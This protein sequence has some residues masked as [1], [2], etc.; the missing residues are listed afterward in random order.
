M[1][2]DENPERTPRYRG[3]SYTRPINSAKAAVPVIELT[4]R[5]D[6]PGGLRRV[7]REWVGRCTA[8]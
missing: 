8:S 1:I 5:L 3:V 4:N 7:G 2:T 6:G